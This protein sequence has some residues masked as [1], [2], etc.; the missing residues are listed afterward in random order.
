MNISK[1][2]IISIYYTTLKAAYDNGY[3]PLVDEL[4]I[5]PEDNDLKVTGLKFE[6]I[7]SASGELFNI[8]SEKN[9]AHTK[10]KVPIKILQSRKV[11]EYNEERFA[12]AF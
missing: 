5:Y 7:S 9:I 11:I 6:S 10:N 3:Y 8:R 12:A 2:P 1:I 4:L